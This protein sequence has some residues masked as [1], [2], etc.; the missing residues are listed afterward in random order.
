M[1]KV[2][3]GIV[4]MVYT[5][6]D[7][8]IVGMVYMD[9]NKVDNTNVFDMDISILDSKDTDHNHNVEIHIGFDHLNDLIVYDKP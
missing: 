1:D 8:G 3:K 2:D 9:M 4:G 7:K 5:D 6:M